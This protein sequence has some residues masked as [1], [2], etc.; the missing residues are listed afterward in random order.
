MVPSGAVASAP[1]DACDDFLPPLLLR[2]RFAGT[3]G[4]GCKAPGFGS[5]SSRGVAG[6]EAGAGSPGGK[7]QMILL[8]VK[9]SHVGLWLF[10]YSILC[11]PVTESNSAISPRK[12]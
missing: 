6:S 7:R 3:T 12:N 9:L 5:T 10:V 2:L 4:A 11:F 8:A 1:T